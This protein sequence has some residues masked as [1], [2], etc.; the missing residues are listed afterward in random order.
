VAWSE[1]V[2]DESKMT[3]RF[4]TFDAGRTILPEMTIGSTEHTSR[5]LREPSQ[6][7][8]VFDELSRKRLLSIQLLMSS[9]QADIRRVS[10][11]ISRVEQW[12]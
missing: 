12:L 6:I 5:R 8:S 4:L 1:N 9:M 10:G 2:N 11:S 3:P 7:T